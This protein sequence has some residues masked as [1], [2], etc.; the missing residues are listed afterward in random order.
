MRGKL[1]VATSLVTR[2]VRESR[3]SMAP[4]PEPTLTAVPPEREMALL[5]YDSFSFWEG[6]SEVDEVFDVMIRVSHSTGL[7]WLPTYRSKL[8]RSYPKF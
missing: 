6:P 3:Y 1:S 2:G 4:S 5:T 7:F 8:V